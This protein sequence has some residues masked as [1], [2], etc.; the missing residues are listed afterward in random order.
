MIKRSSSEC[1]F[2]KKTSITKYGSNAMDVSGGKK[3][4]LFC[5]DSTRYRLYMNHEY[6][7]FSMSNQ[8]NHLLEYLARMG[9][10]VSGSSVGRT[11]VKRSILACSPI[12]KKPAC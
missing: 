6:H 1:P 9:S 5:V 4:I 10:V 3:V 2:I 11:P 7:H 8:T 12:S